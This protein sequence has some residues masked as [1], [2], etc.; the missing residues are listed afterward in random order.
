MILFFKIVVGIA[1]GMAVVM[2]LCF[3][4]MDMVDGMLEMYWMIK[5]MFRERRRR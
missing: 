1:I 2:A 5:D 3:L 4:L